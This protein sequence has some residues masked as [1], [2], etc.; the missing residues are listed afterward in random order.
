[1]LGGAMRRLAVVVLAACG[2]AKAPPPAASSS[3]PPAHEMHGHDHEHH[4]EGGPLVHRF[5]K[6]DEWA[7]VFDDPKR[8]AWQQPDRVVTALAITPGMTVADVGAGTGYFEK[9]LSTAVG[10]SGRVLAVDVE[11]DMIRYLKERAAK[12][13]TPNVEPRLATPEDAALGTAAVDRILIVDTWHHIPEREA[14]AKKLAAA[15]KPGGFVL[16]V[17][18][19]QVTDRGP[20]KPMRIPPEQ[21]A[22]ELQA[23]GLHTSTVDAGLPDQFVIKAAL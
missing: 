10:A 9:R 4:H 7:P 22:K 3:S 2:G 16:V 19:T 6:A 21:V 5:E 23:G 14:Y 11:P 1:M 17:D 13:N 12:E 8:D 18:F 15:L 20:P